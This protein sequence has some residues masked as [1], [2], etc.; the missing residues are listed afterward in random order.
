MLAA[1]LNAEEYF[2]KTDGGAFPLHLH[3]RLLLAQ[4]YSKLRLREDQEA[5]LSPSLSSSP[6]LLCEQEVYS[7]TLQPPF[8]HY[9][10]IMCTSLSLL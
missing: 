2:W 7:F 6:A 5:R 4:A 9:R 3:T 8:F 1:P 10:N